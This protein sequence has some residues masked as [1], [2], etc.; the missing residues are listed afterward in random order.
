MALAVVND[1]KQR[2]LPK[3]CAP[4]FDL[5]RRV[6]HAPTPSHIMPISRRA[7][8][9]GLAFCFIGSFAGLSCPALADEKPLLVFAAASLQ[10]ALAPIA[11]RWMAEG[12]GKVVFSFASSAALAKQIEAGAPADLFAS[13]DPSWMDALAA[14]NHVRADSIQTFLGNELVLVSTF[15]NPVAL[16]IKPGFPLAEALGD[17]KL[18]TGTPDIVPLGTYAKQALTHLGIWDQLAGKIAGTDNARMALT[19]IARGEARYAIV[20]ASD[21]KSTAN[22]RLV[23]TFP[24]ESHK[25]IRYPF[26]I[27]AAS[28]HAQAAAFLAYLRNDASIAVFR[29]AGFIILP[30]GGE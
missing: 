6:T 27:T 15:E 11:E 8:L 4:I 26:G 23:D 9:S 18:A 30:T 25:P 7:H 29:D 24:T 1:R 14:Q 10:P 19:L 16:D 5:Q 28:Q 13:A 22:L 21:A 17:G 2:E 20:Y 3:G 12:R